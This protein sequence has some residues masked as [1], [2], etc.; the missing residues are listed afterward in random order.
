MIQGERTTVIKNQPKFA[1][2][3][4][5]RRPPRRPAFPDGPRRRRFP[6]RRRGGGMFAGNRRLDMYLDEEVNPR[7]R[8]Q[9][10]KFMSCGHCQELGQKV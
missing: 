4:R 6:I 3:H 5:G 10:W 2:D 9:G 8:E 1:N 7:F